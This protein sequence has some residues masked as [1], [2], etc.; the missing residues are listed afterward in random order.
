MSVIGMFCV[1]V[2]NLTADD[3]L[4]IYYQLLDKL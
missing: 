1:F 2:K 4:S 3:S